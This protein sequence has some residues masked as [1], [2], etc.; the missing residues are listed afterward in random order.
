M[1][2][3]ATFEILQ[4]VTFTRTFSYYTPGTPNVAVDLTGQSLRLEM[5]DDDGFVKFTLD[6]VDGANANGS[7]LDITDDDGGL[8]SLTITDEDTARI[9]NSTGQWWIGLNNA[10]TIRRIAHG[11]MT[12]ARP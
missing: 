2:T 3:E 7:I 4:G 12:S 8:F 6:S 9:T 10:G 5:R 11:P 1:A